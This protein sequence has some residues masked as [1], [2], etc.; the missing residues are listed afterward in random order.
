MLLFLMIINILFSTPKNLRW[1]ILSNIIRWSEFDKTKGLWGRYPSSH[2]SILLNLEVTEAVLFLGVRKIHFYKWLRMNKV[3]SNYSLYVDKY[4]FE[5]IRLFL[6]G[7]EG[8]PYATL[9]AIGIFIQRVAKTVFKKDIANPF[10]S[11]TR[12][13]KCSELGAEVLSKW[14]LAKIDLPQESI[15]V[16]HLENILKGTR[17]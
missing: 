2:V 1:L 15:G 16:R 8:V 14:N 6:E 5:D 10:G 4:Q 13:R 17:K 3:Q 7:S 11:A 9:S 12:K